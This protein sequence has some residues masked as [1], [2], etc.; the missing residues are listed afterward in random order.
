M[1]VIGTGLLALATVLFSLRAA[2]SFLGAM[3]ATAVGSPKVS[4]M[5]F[6]FMTLTV[7]AESQIFGSI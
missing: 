2:L 6:I 7:L 1:L 3:R 5:P 4:F